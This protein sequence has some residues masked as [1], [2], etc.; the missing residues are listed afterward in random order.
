MDESMNRKR[1]I[2]FFCGSFFFGMFIIIIVTIIVTMIMIVFFFRGDVL[3]FF[4][5]DDFGNVFVCI[6][7]F[8]LID[9]SVEFLECFF[10]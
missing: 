1:G 8:V 3:F 5:G 10:F 4:W 9:F 7:V 2:H 6:F